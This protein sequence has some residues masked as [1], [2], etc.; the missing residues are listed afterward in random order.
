MERNNPRYGAFTVLCRKVS[1]RTMNFLLTGAKPMV[2][3]DKYAI[4]F[5]FI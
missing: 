1:Q 3:N 2:Y 4:S 5:I